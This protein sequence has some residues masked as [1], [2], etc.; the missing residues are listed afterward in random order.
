VGKAELF[1]AVR[2]PND[3]VACPDSTTAKGDGILK[4]LD[5]VYSYVD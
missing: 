2:L 4:F 5:E 1:G 3:K